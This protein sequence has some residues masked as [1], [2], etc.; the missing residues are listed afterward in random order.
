MPIKK[1]GAAR[2]STCTVSLLTEQLRMC[3]EAY[4]M[5]GFKTE[6]GY[7]AWR[8]ALLSSMTPAADSYNLEGKV[9]R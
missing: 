2:S 7:I 3:Q 4:Q 5:W 6:G 8:E 1:G 9:S